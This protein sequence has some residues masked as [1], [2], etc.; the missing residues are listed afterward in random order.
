MI[1]SMQMKPAERISEEKIAKY[2]GSSR[3]PIRE[4]LKRLA[5]EGLVNLYPN[6]YAEVANY[7]DELVKQIGVVRVFHDIAAIKL[8]VLF[9][10]KADF[11]KMRELAEDCYLA[12]KEG[13][14]ALRIRK[15]CEFHM[16]LSNISKNQQLCKFA[17]ELY[18][19]IEFIQAFRYVDLIGLEE[20]FKE[21]S[22]I[23]DLLVNRQEEEAIEYLTRHNSRF[24]RI[25]EQYPLDFFIK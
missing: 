6:R 3:A 11:N 24:H 2:F 14:T 22:T 17:K 12:A 7:S 1:L 19:R 25:S 13:N 4:A 20:Q 5:H 15:D 21:H 16:E 10:C 18:I 9:G 23:I 8:V